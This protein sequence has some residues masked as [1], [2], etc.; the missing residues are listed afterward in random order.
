MDYLKSREIICIF[1][2]GG[3]ATVPDYAVLGVCE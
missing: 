2:V 1:Y 3:S